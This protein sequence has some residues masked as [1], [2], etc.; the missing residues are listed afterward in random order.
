MSDCRYGGLRLRAPARAGGAQSDN[1][2]AKT[3]HEIRPSDVFRTTPS[4]LDRPRGC[5]SLKRGV[6]RW[7]NL[8]AVAAARSP[9]P[10]GEGLGVGVAGRRK[11]R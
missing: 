7:V 8:N 1:R 6:R 9:P 11:V 3:P 5:P 4:F 10:C 2:A